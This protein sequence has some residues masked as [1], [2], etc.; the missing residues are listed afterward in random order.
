MLRYILRL[1]KTIDLCTLLITERSLATQILGSLFKIYLA[2][3]IYICLCVY[4]CMCIYIY[5]YICLYHTHTY[6][7]LCVYGGMWVDGQVGGACVH[8]SKP[9]SVPRLH[10]DFEYLCN[11]RH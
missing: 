6:M 5:I 9:Y 4:V 1:T 11:T 10:K 7:C 2:R 8:L 3:G